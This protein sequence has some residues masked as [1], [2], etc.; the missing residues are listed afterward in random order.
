MAE[1]TETGNLQDIS[2]SFEALRLLSSTNLLTQHKL[3]QH[4]TSDLIAGQRYIQYLTKCRLNL[5]L[6]LETVEKLRSRISSERELCIKNLIFC[7]V[8]MFLEKHEN[9]FKDFYENISRLAVADEKVEL[10]EEFINTVL[11][12]VRQDGILRGV[13]SAKELEVKDCIEKLIMQRVYKQLM[14]PNDDAD[15]SRDM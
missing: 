6:S 11:A 2:Y 14:F 10:L 7:C 13:L 8:R 1:A 3:F 15:K 4:L 12:E 9:Q 5:L